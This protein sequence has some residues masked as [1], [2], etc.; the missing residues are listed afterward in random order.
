M[1]SGLPNNIIKLPGVSQLPETKEYKEI[2]STM[3]TVLVDRNKISK[4]KHPPFQRPLRLNH[5]VLEIRDLIKQNG[6]IIPGVITIGVLN[7]TDYY[8]MDGQHRI[9]AF[10]KSELPESIVDIRFCR[11]DT[12]AEMGDE[13]VRI[14]SAIVSMRP[15]DILR[16]LEESSPALSEIRRKCP[17]I[18]YDMIR[19]NAKSP[20]VSM[21]N[22]L[23]AW[24]GSAADI[25]TRP[26]V[27]TREILERMDSVETERMCHYFGV[28]WD[29]WRN[30]PEYQRMW[31][32]INVTVSAWMWRH[33]V[34]SQ[35]SPRVT[36]LTP[37]QFGQGMLALTADATYLE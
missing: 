28:V 34:I 30:D 36:R 23:R 8:L 21:A 2:K 16:A 13:F 17:F 35:S 26:N 11:F 3:E 31:S 12:M 5:R 15:D 20:V 6:G 14:N 32:A 24:L 29:A 37:Q 27:T 10:I 7:N 22:A 25:P 4:W 33:C 18:G 1:S 9:D 19:R